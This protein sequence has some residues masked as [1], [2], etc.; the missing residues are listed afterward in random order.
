MSEGVK[1]DKGK[2]RFDLIPSE[3]ITGMAKA[4]T[5]GLENHEPRNWEKGMDWSRPFAALQRHVW[6][7]WRGE[8]ID[9]DSG[10]NHLD[11]ALAE[12]AFLRTYQ[13]RNVGQDNRENLH[14]RDARALHGREEKEDE[15]S[16]CGEIGTLHGES[17]HCGLLR[18]HPGRC[19]D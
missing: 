19:F 2:L 7:W 18:G 10:L 9:K 4:L 11:C 14:K 16:C 17:I 12:L 13:D 6:A 3:A 5:H 15:G 8:T 1:H